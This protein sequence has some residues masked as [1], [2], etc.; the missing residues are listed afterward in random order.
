MCM[1]PSVVVKE[2]LRVRKGLSTVP[3]VTGGGC[4]LLCG[5]LEPEDQQQVLLA[6]EVSLLAPQS[7][8]LIQSL[9]R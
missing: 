2:A 5:C 6:A 4:A 7:S 8:S 1:C 9:E 3:G